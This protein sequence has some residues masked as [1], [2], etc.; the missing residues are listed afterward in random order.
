MEHPSLLS[1]EF[2]AMTEGC[3]SAIL[4]VFKITDEHYTKYVNRP[5]TFFRIQILALPSAVDSCCRS[6][7]AIS[8]ISSARMR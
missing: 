8:L 1:A 7:A 6:S 3:E 4:V 2:Y 5:N